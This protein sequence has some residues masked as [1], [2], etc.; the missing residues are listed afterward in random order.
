MWPTHYIP[1]QPRVEGVPPPRYYLTT[2]PYPLEQS[3]SMTSAGSNP[4]SG[5]VPNFEDEAYF[6]TS[7][8]ALGGTMRDV[9]IRYTG[10]PENIQPGALPLGG[11]L[12]ERLIRY[13]GPPENIQPAAL[14]LGGIMRDPLVTYD[15]WLL[16]FATESFTSG[17]LPLGGSLT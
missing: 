5:F 13:T 9:L 6:T 3:E 2:P 10:P 16:G 1:N 11:A 4:T 15:N 17:G 7:A 14:P 12:V 8:A